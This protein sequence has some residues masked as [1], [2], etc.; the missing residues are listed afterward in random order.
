MKKILITWANWM[1]ATDFITNFSNEFDIF[2][3]DKK[4]LDITST[5]DIESKVKK[6]NPDI[7]LNCA[8]YTAVDDAEDIWMK[9][10]YDINT[11][12]V[13]NLAKITKKY[14]IDLI[15]I[16]TDY[17]FDGL[18]KDWYKENDKC[19]PINQYGMSKYLWEKLSKQENNNS[20]IIRTSW[21]YWWW[22]DFKNFVN[23]MI[24]LSENHKELKIIN[25][26]FW[27]PTNTLDLSEAICKVINNI[28]KY[29]GQIFHFSNS[30]NKSITWFD[31]ASEI[32]KIR[33]KEIKVIPC[34]SDEFKTKAKRPM[35]SRMINSSD[36][37]LRDWKEGLRDYINKLTKWN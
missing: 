20:I 4:W 17:V 21:L 18:N 22:K 34:A 5:L 15:T 27:V 24:K 29:R 13:Y 9:L 37:V 11:L 1:L 33:W 26:Q 35:F 19:G 23:T 6:I 28:E 12:W 14:N 25:D 32:F 31:F 2:S 3:F 30:S 36:I 8:A 7:I 10:N 16:S